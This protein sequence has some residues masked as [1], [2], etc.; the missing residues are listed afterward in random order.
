MM[1]RT[2]LVALGAALVP[3]AGAA[4][5]APGYIYEFRVTGGDAPATGT[6]QVVGD[7]ARVDFADGSGQYFLITAG[8]HRITVVNTERH[9]YSVLDDSTF[10]RLV[11]QTLNALPMLNIA[12]SGVR[13]DGDTLGA[14]GPILGHPTDHYR[15]TQEFTLTIGAFGITGQRTHNTVVTDYWLAR[16]LNLP[17]NPVVGMLARLTTVLAQADRDFAHRTAEAL[18][19]VAERTPLRIE[20]RSTADQ[21]NGKVRVQSQAIEVTSLERARV[22]TTRFRVPDGYTETQ[23]NFNLRL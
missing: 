17:H 12:L 10:D 19:P 23:P 15:L 6:T 13:V 1:L 5:R 22:D 7:R 14:G 16:D 4:Q 18:R 9:E 8:G 3:L 2:P 21:G 20:V 11:G